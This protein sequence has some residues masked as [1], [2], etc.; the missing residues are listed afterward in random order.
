[1]GFS[2]K[3]KK[4][5]LRHSNIVHGVVIN[6]RDYQGGTTIAVKQSAYHC[7]LCKFRGTTREEL[8]AHRKRT[9]HN[10]YGG[11]TAVDP[12]AGRGEE[13]EDQKQLPRVENVRLT[14]IW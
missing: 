4:N 6:D 10:K 14:H 12:I 11:V 13:S 8:A 3:S 1:M 7:T 5:M 2:S 9:I